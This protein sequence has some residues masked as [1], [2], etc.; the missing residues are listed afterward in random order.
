MP[1]VYELRIA[2]KSRRASLCS[3]WC[4]GHV[5]G[6]GQAIATLTDGAMEFHVPRHGR[7]FWWSGWRSMAMRSSGRCAGRI[8]CE[9]E[10]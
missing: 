2:G 1:F 10:R 3:S 7:G 4:R 5:V 8:V 6:T 9:G